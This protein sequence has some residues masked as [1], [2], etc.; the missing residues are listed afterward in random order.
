M[1]HKRGKIEIVGDLLAE[2]VKQ[3]LPKSRV[4]GIVGMSWVAAAGYLAFM[5]KKGLV[6]RTDEDGRVVYKATSSGAS[7]AA[8]IGWI[9]RELGEDW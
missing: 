6:T 1:T 4:M 9:K 3:P 7:M 2:I 8:K 5:E